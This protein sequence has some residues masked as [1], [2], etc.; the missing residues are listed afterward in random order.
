LRPLAPAAV[1]SPH[2]YRI[3]IY[4]AGLAW[5]LLP[6]WSIRIGVAPVT[7]GSSDYLGTVALSRPGVMRPG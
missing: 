1:D 5:D 3:A 6:V 7:A 2:A 4:W